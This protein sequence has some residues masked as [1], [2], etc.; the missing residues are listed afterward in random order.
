MGKFKKANKIDDTPKFSPK[1]TWK[2][3]PDV[4]LILDGDEIAFR[5]AAAC[6]QTYLQYKNVVSGGVGNFKNK[7]QFKE[8]MADVT[9]DEEQ[10]S[11]ELVVV[12]EPIANA[13]N[14]MKRT[15]DNFCSKFECH[16][17]NVEI[18]IGGE[19]N[20]RLDL[21]LPIKYKSNRTSERPVLLDDLK[22]YLVNYKGATV[23][24]GIE[25]DDVL[26]MRMVEGYK[27]TKKIIS[28][29]LDKDAAQTCGWLYNPNKDELKFLENDLGELHID[30]STKIESIKGT[31]WKWLMFQCIYGD[32]VDVYCPRDIYEQLHGKK[33]KFGE[34][35]AYNLLVDTTSYKDS[36]S[37]V[38]DLYKK[39]YGDKEPVKFTAWDGSEQSMMW[40]EILNMY[41]LC[42]YMRR[43]ENDTT[44]M[45]D[46]LKGF[47]LL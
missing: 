27:S 23:V 25:A 16:P 19:G 33:P 21:P 34:K 30:T 40:Y 32:P 41:F 43:K 3:D 42:A 38:C 24:E 45:I 28:I 14:T 36:L 8:F 20:F 37:K 18:Y 35:S 39:W 11:S 7:T 5:T 46:I 17:D 47:N 9:F 10:F 15:I 2:V 26:V 12:A 22:Q 13:I 4:T 1:A 6:Q 29:T 44:N 31:G